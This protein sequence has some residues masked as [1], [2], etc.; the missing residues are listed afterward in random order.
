MP[1]ENWQ[2]KPCRC[3][4]S[5]SRLTARV[6]LGLALLDQILLCQHGL[7]CSA[8]LSLLT[9]FCI[10]SSPPSFSAEALQFSPGL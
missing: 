8:F 9:L 3:K 1:L 10:S 6:I 2:Q 4:N 5:H 7:H